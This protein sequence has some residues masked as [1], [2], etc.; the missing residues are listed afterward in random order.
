MD[1]LNG[2]NG[3]P[4]GSKG[5]M[6]SLLDF[7]ISGTERMLKSGER[8]R[9]ILSPGP[10]SEAERG[11][12]ETTLPMLIAAREKLISFPE[13]Q[14]VPIEEICCREWASMI[15]ALGVRTLMGLWAYNPDNLPGLYER[16]KPVSRQ[17]PNQLHMYYFVNKP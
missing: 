4:S 12:L 1:H 2:T 10:L 5:V 16:C 17:R 15:R 6:V 13:Q 9:N 14:D 8:D 7:A 11:E 3:R